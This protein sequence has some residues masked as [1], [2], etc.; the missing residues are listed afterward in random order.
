[1]SALGKPFPKKVRKKLKK[2]QTI[3]AKIPYVNKKNNSEKNKLGS[4]KKLGLE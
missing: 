3:K 4:N 2:K 1:M